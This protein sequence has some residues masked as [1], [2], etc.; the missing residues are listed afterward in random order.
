[1]KLAL[2]LAGLV[3]SGT[4]I[5][6]A[7]ARRPGVPPSR[8]FSVVESTIPA[9]RAALEERRGTSRELV[10]QYLARIAMYEDTLHAALVVS[11]R[12][13]EDAD[14]LD[15][16]RAQGRVTR[17]ERSG[18]GG[19]RPAA[20]PRLHGVPLRGGLK[21]ARIGVPR[22][23]F[24]ERTT[25]PGEENSRGGLSDDQRKVMDEALA[26]LKREGAL[27]VDPAEIPSVIDTDPEERLHG[28][29]R[30][31]PDTGSSA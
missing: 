17:S 20:R 4:L 6:G 21:G 1:M 13:L 12:A 3:A 31:L 5:L 28:R 22:A 23:F 7:Q 10:G 2:G 26:V 27:V 11:R 18:D 30:S 8:S 9:M 15:S 29:F 19:V 25:A 14:R 16:E 24:Y